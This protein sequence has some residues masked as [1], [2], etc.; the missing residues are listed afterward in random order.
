MCTRNIQI[1]LY[2]LLFYKNKPNNF[3]NSIDKVRACD[4]NFFDKVNMCLHTY[5]YGSAYTIS[6]DF[7]RVRPARE[8]SAKHKAYLV[9]KLLLNEHNTVSTASAEEILKRKIKNR[10]ELCR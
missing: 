7:E 9:E 8:G 6:K 2:V 5:A 4:Y 10:H 3:R 1:I